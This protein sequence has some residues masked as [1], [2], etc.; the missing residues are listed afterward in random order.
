V[1]LV[2]VPLLA[3]STITA[4]VRAW[5]RTHAPIVR[6]EMNGRRGH[7]VIFDRAVFE[8]LRQAPL[9]IG[10]R[11]VVSAHYPE[12]VNVPV[13]DPGCILD[14]DTPEDYRAVTTRRI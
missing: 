12:I 5:E 9:A 11:A 13:D 14:I 3:V 2:D 4:V 1:T 6:P 10:A 8:E 7:P